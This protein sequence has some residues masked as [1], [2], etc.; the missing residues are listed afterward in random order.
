MLCGEWIR[1]VVLGMTIF[2]FGFIQAWI[3]EAQPADEALLQSFAWRNIGP[4]NMGG[5]V[6][7]IEAV[8]GQFAHVYLASASGGVWKSLN[9]GTTWEPIF[10]RYGTASIGDI[11]L[12]KDDPDVVWVGTGEANNRNSV[13]W[14]DGMYK[15]TDGGV[16]FEHMGLES[17]HQIARVVIHP[18]TSDTVFACAI[19]HLWGYSGDRG[20]FHTR[21]G[22]ITWNKL[23][24][25]LPNDGKTGCTDLVM[26]PNNPDVLYAAFYHRLRQP[27]T[28]HSGGPNGGIFKSTDGGTTWI[29]LTRGLPA[30]DTG[31]IGLA[32][33]R[34]NPNI[35]MALVEATRTDDL[36]IPGSGLYRSEDAGATW[37]YVNTYNNRP[38]YY[39]QIRINP[40][41]DQRIYVLTTRFMVSEDGGQTLVN[42]SL[43]QE[44]HGDF[45]AMWLDPTNKDRYYI[46][47]DKGAS[48]THDHGKHF[49]LFDNLPL[50]QFY[51]IGVDMRDPYYVYGGLQDNGT[52]GVPSFTRDA[53]GILNDS[54]W[55]LHWGDGQDIQID[56]TNWRKVYTEM[57]NG[58]SF[59]YD[60]L[61]HQIKSIRPHPGNIVNYA[62]A[63]PEEE[64]KQGSEFRFNWSAPLVMSPHNSQTLYVGANRLF[65][66][67]NGGQSWMIVSPDLT[68][69][70]PIKSVRGQSGGLTPDNSGA[71]QHC[72]ITTVALSPLSPGVI[73]VGTDDSNVQ[74][75]QDGGSNWT[76][77]RLAIPD[78]PEG[79]WVSRIEASHFSEGTAYISFDG[80]R[81]DEFTPWIF[82][83]HD[84]GKTWRRITAGIPEGQVVRVIRED[85]KNPNLLFAG[86][87]TGVL[88][89]LNAGADWKPFMH[90]LPTV[91]IYDLVIHPR[92]NDLIAGTHGRSLW[93]A[94]DLSPLQQ[95]NSDI[96]ASKGHVFEQE[97]VT[98]WENTS[99][100]GQ[101]GHFWF[102]GTNPPTIENTSSLP[103]AGFRSTASIA[104][105]ISDGSAAMSMEILGPAG[106]RHEIPLNKTPGIHQYIWNLRFD[107][108]PL[109]DAQKAEGTAFFEQAL[110]QAPFASVRAA[111]ERFNRATTP[112]EALEAIQVINNGY[113]NIT[114]PDEFSVPTATPGTYTIR[115][116]IDGKVQDRPLTVRADPIHNTPSRSVRVLPEE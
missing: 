75:T 25:G 18:E 2:V 76:N 64:R 60:A 42:G 32:I 74:V 36:A 98:L 106:L 11:A 44:I 56:P 73:W 93:I 15:S 102:A 39:S 7:D 5:R 104:Y 34:Q 3:V 103:R 65:K 89:S 27:W 58:R 10:D 112:I 68:T 46:G 40:H 13:S 108:N 100:G 115:L 59:T 88:I 110:Q 94:D 38:F 31:R 79:I 19:G 61:T 37:T 26:D 96:T 90:G 84:F 83:T 107:P 91:S 29:K 55:K 72:S 17:T 92:T 48:I 78:V 54:N 49:Q 8:E 43:D 109:T 114:V 105:Y 116:T 82:V 62:S 14:G 87:E 20:L 4:A 47:A 86:T 69:N 41:D 71:E 24:G 22:G 30:G 33:Y 23:A 97:P 45:H 12:A 52:Y 113:F 95:L 77:V 9:A 80:H 99:R 16:H 111:Y 1:V 57:E 101:R 70:D 50:G 63:I 85:P 6:V 51:R 28:F 66:S 53:R 81:S 35:I 67:E 21:D